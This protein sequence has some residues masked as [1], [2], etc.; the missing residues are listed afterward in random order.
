MLNVGGNRI[1]TEEIENVLLQ[2]RVTTYRRVMS[3]AL[4]TGVDFG[5][6]AHSC[7]RPLRF[8]MQESATVANCA[9]VGMSDDVLG[10][11]PVAF[12]VLQARDARLP[13]FGPVGPSS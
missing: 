11:V 6:S 7:S 8:R 12:V 9:V 2:E 13:A 4:S 5:E 10:S 3:H 1:G